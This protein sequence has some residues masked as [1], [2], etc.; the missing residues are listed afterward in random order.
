[1]DF[2]LC[3]DFW[4]HI[5]QPSQPHASHDLVLKTAL[6]SCEDQPKHPYL[7]QFTLQLKSRRLDWN[8]V[9]INE[10][11]NYVVSQKQCFTLTLHYDFITGWQNGTHTHTHEECMKYMLF[12][13]LKSKR[14]C[15]RHFLTVLLCNSKVTADVPESPGPNTITGLEDIYRLTTGFS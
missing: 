8:R 1:M 2:Y 15:C 11:N 12:L 6:F 5:L 14:F 3:K 7:E 4:N 9:W 13:W 10:N